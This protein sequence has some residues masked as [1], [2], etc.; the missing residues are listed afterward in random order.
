MKRKKEF[1][2]KNEVNNKNHSHLDMYDGLELGQ[3]HKTLWSLSNQILQK[4]TKVSKEISRKTKWKS[5]K[6]RMREWPA[7]K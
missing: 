2:S 4:E 7:T 1:E 5:E 6:E 3:P